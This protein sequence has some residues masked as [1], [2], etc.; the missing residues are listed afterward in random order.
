MAR[1]G[2]RRRSSPSIAI[3][4]LTA[5]LAVRNVGTGVETDDGW[6]GERLLA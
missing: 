6:L 5:T 3:L 2:L 1:F 4:L